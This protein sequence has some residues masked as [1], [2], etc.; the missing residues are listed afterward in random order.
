MTM[1]RFP[2]DIIEAVDAKLS[3]FYPG[4]IV[5]PGLAEAVAE[6][7]VG[8]RA[9]AAREALTQQAQELNMGYDTPFP[10]KPSGS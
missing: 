3:S 6:L 4:R 10:P 8:E 9:R 2:P 5:D 7:V 1:T